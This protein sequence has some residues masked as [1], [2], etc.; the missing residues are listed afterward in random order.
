MIAFRTT[1]AVGQKGSSEKCRLY[2]LSSLAPCQVS[3]AVTK[4]QS[5]DPAI[6]SAP[7][8]TTT[9][10]SPA[11]SQQLATAVTDLKEM[12]DKK[13]GEFYAACASFHAASLQGAAKLA[14]AAQKGQS[15][16]EG[17][18]RAAAA[19]AMAR[20]TA[21][22]DSLRKQVKEHRAHDHRREL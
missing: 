19:H 14:Q 16:P 10:A 3:A 2:L 20:Q 22:L 7:A 18:R 4:L 5:V 9:A 15:Q 1:F 13:L 17:A 12:L 11:L 6:P 21:E 8:R